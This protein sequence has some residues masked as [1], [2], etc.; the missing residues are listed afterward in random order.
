M[1]RSIFTQTSPAGPSPP[2]RAAAARGSWLHSRAPRRADCS[3]W[4]PGGER[5]G[6]APSLGT[7]HSPRSDCRG[8][9]SGFPDE[10]DEKCSQVPLRPGCPG[11]SSQTAPVPA[12]CPP[13]KHAASLWSAP[14]KLKPPRSPGGQRTPLCL[15]R[16]CLAR[17]GAGKTP[18]SRAALGGPRS[19]KAVGAREEAP[20]RG[21][22]AFSSASSFPGQVLA[23]R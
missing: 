12:G 16:V 14:R 6:P 4:V 23:I 19:A 18:E 22:P 7:R 13:P 1:P 3:P 2:N 10:A 20:A 11:T 8:L 9:R 17:S 5:P 21:F 15:R